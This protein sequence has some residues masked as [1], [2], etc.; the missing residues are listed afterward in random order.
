MSPKGFQLILCSWFTLLICPAVSQ[1]NLEELKQAYQKSTDTVK[2]E[3]LRQV[4]RAS[5]RQNDSALKYARIGFAESEK[6]G[7]C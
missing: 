2:L 5:I 3:V 4:T 1:N 7:T 6:L